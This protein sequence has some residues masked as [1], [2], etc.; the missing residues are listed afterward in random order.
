MKQWL[1]LNR[2]WCKALKADFVDPAP[3]LP[4]VLELLECAR[5]MNLRLSLRTDATAAPADLSALRNAGLLDVCLSP[6]TLESPQMAA[7]ICACRQA[8]LPVRVL[9]QA[10]WAAS[11]DVVS[12]ARDL[13]AAGAVVV[14]FVVRD[15]LRKTEVCPERTVA[16][17]SLA[18]MN[19]LAAALAGEGIEVN[20]VGVPPEH[21]DADNHACLMSSYESARDQ[22][23]YMPCALD[24][25]RRLYPRPLHVA[26]TILAIRTSAKTSWL[27]K[28]DNIVFQFLLH[29]REWL[30]EKVLFLHKISRFVPLFSGA[31][32]PVEDDWGFEH[33][34]RDA[35]DEEDRAAFAAVYPALRA[36]GAPPVTPSRVPRTRYWDAVDG[37]RLSR[38]SAETERARDALLHIGNTPPDIELGPDQWRAANGHTEPIP[39]ALRWF[40]GANVEKLSTPLGRFA[41]PLTLSVVI[42]GGR[43]EFAGFAFG[44]HARLVCP[45]EADA[46][47]LVL[48]VDAKGRCV[49]IRDDR[50]V[51]PVD[52]SGD[53]YV[54]LGLGSV[55]EPRLSL[56]NIDG[57]VVTQSPQVWT[58]QAPVAADAAEP[59]YSVVIV[60]TRY[61]R[62]L[63]AA[64]LG[65]ARQRGFDLS[66]IEIL[67][68]YVPGMD[69][70]EDVL[71][72]LQTAFPVLTMRRVP[73][74]EQHATAK[75]YLIN[76]TVSLARGE[77]VILLDADIVLPPVFLARLEAEKEGCCF[78]AP[79]GRKMLDPDTTNR[80]LLGLLNPSM[81]WESLLQG[82]GEFRYR[83]AENTPVGYCQCVRRACFQRV[84]Y[85]EYGHFEGADWTFAQEMREVFGRARRLE[86]L[87]VLHLDHGASQW[88][89]VYKQL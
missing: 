60:C 18:G 53:Y 34:N 81:A 22:Q 88:Y 17:A 49:L 28:L 83:E 62:R 87:P 50:P 55:L 27:N 21:V 68:A 30:L 36:K 46:H 32:R 51:A 89:G 86:G 85:R 52:F 9:L 63:Q 78:V 33:L 56:W 12:A 1:R 38:L 43:A 20:I 67:L 15:P 66:R 40:G 24:W 6:K 42:G 70:A 26:R 41:L 35:M 8:G 82:P 58:H 31:A 45:M 14:N 80:I 7:W 69:A 13:A 48:H 39:G 54:P 5:E 59:A 3:S 25:V 29:K 16:E 65:I 4:Q 84:R 37:E 47:R 57:T 64:L 23:F 61:A 2:F 75:G 71:D 74:V 72:S 10:P 79:D 73:F 44:R 77:W 76:E 19:A 11:P